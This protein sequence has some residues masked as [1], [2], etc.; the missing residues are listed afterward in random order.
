[1]PIKSVSELAV[2]NRSMELAKNVY[3]PSVLDCFG[4]NKSRQ[5]WTKPM[6][7]ALIPNS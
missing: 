7:Q 5:S 4:P 2:W 1:M 6:K 3:S